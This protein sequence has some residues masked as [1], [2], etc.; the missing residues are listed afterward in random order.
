[1]PSVSEKIVTVVRLG[2]GRPELGSLHIAVQVVHCT[3][4]QVTTHLD[5]DRNA[6]F[7]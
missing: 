1:M 5:F 6:L 2:R 4:P 3:T 7:P